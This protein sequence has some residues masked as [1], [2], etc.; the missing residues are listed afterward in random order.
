[1]RYS[2]LLTNA[3]PIYQL[4]VG[5]VRKVRFAEIKVSSKGPYL[6]HETIY[7]YSN[8]DWYRKV[9]IKN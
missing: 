8:K 6:Y 3:Y 5:I 7:K 2:R 4:V 9:E 1:M